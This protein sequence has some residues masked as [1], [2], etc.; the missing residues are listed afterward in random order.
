VGLGHFLT[1]PENR[2][3]VLAAL[4]ICDAVCLERVRNASNPFFIYGSAGI[5]KS[6]LAQELR[7]RVARKRADLLFQCV[8][9]EEI[10]GSY[11]IPVSRERYPDVFVVED[12]Q[13]IRRWEALTQLTDSLR[14]HGKQLIFTA[15][16]GPARL[17]GVPVRTL[18]RLISGL[19]VGMEPLGPQ[20]RLLILEQKAQERQLL[21]NHQV[22]EWLAERLGGGI[23]QLEGAV[24]QLQ[25][26]TRMTRGKI[27]EE[28][29]ETYFGSHADA[30]KATVERIVERVG[31]YFNLHPGELRSRRRHHQ[32]LVPRQLSM[33]LARRL[34]RQPLTRIGTYFGGRDHSTVLHACRKIAR[35]LRHDAALASTVRQLEGELA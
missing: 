27:N 22:L 18:G 2:S 7:S 19:V 21:V 30:I 29:V 8:S 32:A 23:R 28:L 24:A 10:N 34:T 25:A 33:Y 17:P 20:S 15:R 1:I 11:E 13:L 3:A 14:Q 31:A 12:L 26:L 5:G 16:C 4:R 35:C 6:R 9:P